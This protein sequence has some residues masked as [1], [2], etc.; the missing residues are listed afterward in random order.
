MKVFML[1]P[2]NEKFCQNIISGMSGADAYRASYNCSHSR[3]NVIYVRACELL[4]KP[5]VAARIDELRQ[6]IVEKS[7][8]TALDLISELEDVRLKAMEIGQTSAAVSAIM[9]KAKLLGLGSETINIKP[10]KIELV[11]FVE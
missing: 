11:K 8:I 6:E 7:E 3:D 4:K 2:K 9:G 10:P 5:E 1:T